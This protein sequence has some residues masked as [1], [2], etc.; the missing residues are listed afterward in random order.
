M[1]SDPI[2][3]VGGLNTYGYANANPLRWIDFYGLRCSRSF[4]QRAFDNFVRTNEAVVGILA[5][6]G[7]GTLLG[8][9]NAVAAKTG[10]PTVKQAFHSLFRGS[11]R[12]GAAVLTRTETVIA[13]SGTSGLGA[14]LVA[15]AF[16]FGVSIGSIISAAVLPC[17]EVTEN[18]LAKDCQ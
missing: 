16:E 12:T 17:D 11:F 10:T 8:A 15:G 18:E 4:G 14:V 2:G 9:G 1:T 13:A 7:L 5:P 3:L 6:V